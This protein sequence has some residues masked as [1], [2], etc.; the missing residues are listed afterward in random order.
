M[1]ASRSLTLQRGL[2]GP[3]ACGAEWVLKAPLTRGQ[4][5]ESRPRPPPTAVQL[6]TAGGSG[7]IKLPT[8]PPA[9]RRKRTHFPEPHAL[10]APARPLAGH[11]A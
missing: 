8:A 7:S 11:G 10:L 9:Q 6:R 2:A 5:G 4:V 3:W 1:E